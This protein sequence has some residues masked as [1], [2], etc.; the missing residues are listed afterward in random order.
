MLQKIKIDKELVRER[1][2]R[3]LRSYGG[4]AVVQKI[5]AAE[6]AEMICREE[7]TCAFNRVLEVGSGSG[8]FMAEL[9]SRCT[10]KS[11]YANDLVEESSH[12]L[13]KVLD[14]FPVGEFHFLTGDIECRDE[15]PSGLDL[16]ASNATLQWLDD[17]D[18]FFRTMSDHLNPEGIL[19]FSTFSTSNMQEITSIEDVGLLYHSLGDLEI[20]AARHFDLIVSKEDEQRLEF[21]SPEAVLHHIRQTGVN[22]LQRRSWTKSRYQHFVTEYSRLF[23]CENGVYLTYHPVYCCLKKKLL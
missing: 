15:L 19:A 1:F 8:A 10:I 18:G 22:G 20:L 17:L 11:Y 9:L 2:C 4:N 6:L 16:V 12:C 21:R 23:S 3:T 13:Q 5:M 7:P 14:R